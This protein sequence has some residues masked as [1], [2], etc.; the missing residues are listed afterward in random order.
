MLKFF[1]KAV[2]ILIVIYLAVLITVFLL[3]RKAM[4]FPP[5]KYLS[6]EVTGLENVNE[7]KVKTSAGDEVTAWWRPPSTQQSVVMFFHGNGSAVYDGWFI[8]D[9][10]INQGYGVLGV[11]YP[12]YPGATGK[13]SETAL[14]L[15]AEFQYD[16]LIEQGI[17]PSLIYIYGTSLGAGVAAQLAA[18]R[19]VGKIV[20]E[21]PFYSM[22]DMAKI[23]MPW[24]AFKPLIRDKYQSF[25]VLEDVDVPILWLHGTN[26]KVIP[27][28][29]GQR[30]YDGYV[31]PK[32]KM[33][34]S[35][36]QHSNLWISGG[37]ERIISF[38]EEPVDRP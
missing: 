10:F 12:G 36:G 15:A 14:V 13:P 3:Q 8:Y 28:A 31:G 25:R 11:G 7:I 6:P 29:E 33:I 17:D 23:S 5:Q 24:F 35:G 21:A 4:Y 26:D 1:L 9:D 18:R 2:I 27:I 38:L 37:R 30:L 32:E 34:V 20:L 16:F 22:T 19:H